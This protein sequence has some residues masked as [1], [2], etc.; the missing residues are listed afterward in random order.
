MSAKGVL[1]SMP[2]K[3]QDFGGVLA[4]FVDSEGAHCSV[5]AEAA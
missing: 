1:F 2:P 4:P 5:G 3:K